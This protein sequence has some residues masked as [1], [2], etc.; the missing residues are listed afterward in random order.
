MAIYTLVALLGFLTKLVESYPGEL[1][2][3]CAVKEKFHDGE[4][5]ASAN[6][7]KITRPYHMLTLYHPF[8]LFHSV[9]YR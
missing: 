3:S 1:I 8:T 5:Y 9:K 7:M 6:I 2:Y 4:S